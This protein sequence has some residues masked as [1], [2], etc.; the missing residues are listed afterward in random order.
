MELK[1]AQD[2]FQHYF[3]NGKIKVVQKITTGLI[4]ATFFLDSNKGKY[5]LQKLNQ[6]ILKQPKEGLAN[7][8]KV[9][10]WLSQHNFSY[11]FPAPI[12]DKYIEDGVDLWRLLKYVPNSVSYDNITNAEQAFQAA[13]CLGAFYKSTDKFPT[14]E[15]NDTIPNFHNGKIRI[16]EFKQV[17]KNAN[18]NRIDYAR[19]LINNVLD[20]QEV[21]HD[22]DSIVSQLPVRV[23]HYDTKINNF[24][25]DKGSNKVIALIDLDTIMPGSVLSDIGDMIRTYSNPMGEESNLYKSVKADGKIIDSLINGFCSEMQITANESSHLQKAGKAITFMQCVRFLTDYLNNDVYYKTSYAEQNLVRAKNQWC[26]FD[27]L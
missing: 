5:I 26:L 11:Q 10:N 15:L 22:F 6:N 16:E 24:L 20:K 18:A 23:V 21:L 25:F 4:N 14:E 7:I 2:I 13:K 27:S 8:V 19:N 9:K 3:P 17:L 12:F 1:K